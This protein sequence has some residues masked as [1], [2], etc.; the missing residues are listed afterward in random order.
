MAI[1]YWS[2]IVHWYELVGI[3]VT[4]QTIDSEVRALIGRAGLAPALNPAT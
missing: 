1:P 2:T 3:S 4:G